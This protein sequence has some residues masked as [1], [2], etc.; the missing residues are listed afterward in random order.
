MG[1]SAR[2]STNLSRQALYDRIWEKPVSRVAR[3]F[4]ISDVGLAKICRKN[5]IP[6]PP[7]GYW[8]RIAAGQRVKKTVL[9]RPEHNP[10]I[11]IA[12]YP[13]VYVTK[14]TGER[15]S[16][17]PPITVP[18]TLAGAHPIVLTTH[19][20]LSAESPVYDGILRPP[21]DSCLDIRVS[22]KA[23]PRALRIME[24]LIRGL[25]AQ[26]YTVTI[27]KTRR[28][29]LIKQSD[30]EVVLF[31]REGLKRQVEEATASTH[32]GSRY[33][34]HHSQNRMVFAP[35]GRLEIHIR[36]VQ[37]IW[38]HGDG[39]RTKFSDGDRQRL[40]DCLGHVAVS[41]RQMSAAWIAAKEAEA[42]RERDRQLE[43]ARLEAA[44]K[45]RAAMWKK[46]EAEQQ[47]VD[48]LLESSNNWQ[49]AERLRKYIRA[50][51]AKAQA[52]GTPLDADSETG[53]WIAWAYD[54]ANRIDPLVESPR[55]ILDDKDKYHPRERQHW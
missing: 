27:D 2:S 38:G 32:S 21:T 42:K 15:D 12:P 47:R 37:S 3:E 10:M 46:I 16:T 44:E 33:E 6:R 24:G 1:N 4:G 17:Y 11:T 55:S 41:V 30:L 48:Q 45:A 14:Q 18:N 31:I 13:Y 22:P 53:K 51:H 54:Q 49:K 35:C 7:L 26:S 52:E 50:V 23:L 19:K 25:E 9:P 34:F 29:T 8:A 5:D 36:S 40:E 43:R 28:Q 39:I 20:Q